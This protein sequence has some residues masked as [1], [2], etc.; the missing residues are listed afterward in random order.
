[1]LTAFIFLEKKAMLS[2]NLPLVPLHQS[3]TTLEPVTGSKVVADQVN[4]Q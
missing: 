4:K 2:K 3:V 1:M